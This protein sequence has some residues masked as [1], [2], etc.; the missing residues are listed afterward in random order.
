MSSIKASQS[1]YDTRTFLPSKQE[2]R[3]VVNGDRM[4]SG[5]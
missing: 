2:L 3:G 4:L 5:L 1:C